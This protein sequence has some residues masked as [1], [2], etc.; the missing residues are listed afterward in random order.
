MPLCVLWNE[1][2]RDCRMHKLR[3]IIGGS[4]KKSQPNRCRGGG[5]RWWLREVKCGCSTE[6]GG[7]C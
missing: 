2:R 6:V 5:S 1:N 4:K 7:P 3:R